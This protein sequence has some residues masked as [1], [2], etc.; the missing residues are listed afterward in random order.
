M[1]T[2]K[3]YALRFIRYLRRTYQNKVV[4]MA[5]IGVGILSTLIEGDATALVFILMLAIPVFFMDK[6]IIVPYG[7]E[8]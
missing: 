3:K 7:E 2:F 1:A 6:N 4:A 5:M 8:S